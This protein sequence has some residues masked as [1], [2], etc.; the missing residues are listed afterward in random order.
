MEE[1]NV[2]FNA[3]VV[4]SKTRKLPVKLPSNI[5]EDFRLPRKIKKAMKKRLGSFGYIYWLDLIKQ[6]K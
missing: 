2:K 5:T 1:A 4:Q 3:I 6:M